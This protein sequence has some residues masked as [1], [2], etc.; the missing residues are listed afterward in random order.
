M[1]GNPAGADTTVIDEVPALSVPNTPTGPT[2]TKTKTEPASV[3]PRP[4]IKPEPQRFAWAPAPDASAYH[5]E[6]FVGSSRVFEADTKR[7]AL[8]IPV[9]WKFGGRSRSLEHGEYRWYVWPVFSGQ[10]A[11]RAIVQ[12]KLTIPPS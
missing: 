5:V 12:A 6:L 3:P 10:R 11:A 2:K 8:T 7:P 1:A 4:A 9:R